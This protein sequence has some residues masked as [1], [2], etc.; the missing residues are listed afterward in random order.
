M[1]NF[2]RLAPWNISPKVQIGLF[3]TLLPQKY[4]MD[5]FL[6]Q[7]ANQTEHSLLEQFVQEHR[8]PCRILTDEDKEDMVLGRMMEETDYGETVD[9][10][11]FIEQ[12]KAK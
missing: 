2:A 3:F 4:D 8:L 10:M 11:E 12:L 7:T 9:T 5:T 1:S 6:I